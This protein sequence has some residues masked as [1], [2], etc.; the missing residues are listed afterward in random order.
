MTLQRLRQ[1]IL[2]D[3]TLLLMYA[4]GEDRSY[5]WLVDQASISVCALPARREIE[6][7]A[8]LVH[9]LL[10]RSHLR[11]GRVQSQLQSAALAR[12]VIGPVAEKL[13]NKRLVVVADGAL[14]LIPFAILPV[15]SNSGEGAGSLLV[16]DHE[17]IQLPSVS[18]LGAIRYSQHQRSRERAAKHLAIFA[19]PVFDS[20]DPRLHGA[21]PSSETH[22]LDSARAS[23]RPV[24]ARLP[25]SALEA[26]GIVPLIPATGTK[27]A[28]GFAATK[29][30]ASD[31]DLAQFR[32]V[33]FATH[34]LLH[35]LHPELS[36]LVLSL[37]D[38]SNR[39]SN[40]FLRAF[41]IADLD[42]PA[43]LVVLSACRSADGKALRG[44]GVLSLTRAFFQA[45]AASMVVSLWSVNDL[46][47]AELMQRFYRCMKEDGL[48]PAAALRAA[49]ISMLEE[50]QWQ[51]P[52]FWAG[53]VFQGEWLE[54][55]LQ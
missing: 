41:E 46:A 34:G 14:Q 15:A 30:A 17:I 16:L 36:G 54:S 24:F 42:L 31:P 35:E 47:T 7:T 6:S 52:Y 49:Q 25:H 11:R 1:E 32:I 4:L 51:A 45:G 38:G 22:D 39:P 3:D 10:T 26:A 20:R 28:I 37:V 55:P 48:S 40:G 9:Q 8:G 50:P 53:F 33:H 12:M 21:G 23:A 43:E 5:L 2:D 18:V 19:D 29:D 44:E 13:D 27:Q